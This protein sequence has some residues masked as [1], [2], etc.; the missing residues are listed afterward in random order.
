MGVFK[1]HLNSPR[2]AAVW[3]NGFNLDQ[4]SQSFHFYWKWSTSCWRMLIANMAWFATLVMEET[5]NEAGKSGTSAIMCLVIFWH[6]TTLGL[7]VRYFVLEVQ[8]EDDKLSPPGPGMIQSLLRRLNR[9]L[10]GLSPYFLCLFVYSLSCTCN[11]TFW[12]HVI[13]QSSIISQQFSNFQLGQ[14]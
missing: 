10:V 13:F 5:Y 3:M 7:Y 14:K 2:T 1:E 8:R 4:R 6:V 9:V 11:C 12:L